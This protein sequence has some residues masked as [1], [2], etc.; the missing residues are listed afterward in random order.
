MNKPTVSLLPATVENA[1]AFTGSIIDDVVKFVQLGTKLESLRAALAEAINQQIKLSGVTVAVAAKQ[2][3]AD[4]KAAGV[5]KQDASKALL[6]LGIRERAASSKKSEDAK[7]AAE[8]LLP[9]IEELK[10]AAKAK[11][12]DTAEAISVLRRAYLSLAAEN[13]AAE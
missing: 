7:E 4:L 9:I 11:A 8:A 10:A 13:K 1:F 12:A 3:R 5:S 6:A 2:L